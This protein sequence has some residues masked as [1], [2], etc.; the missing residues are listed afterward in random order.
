ME[1]KGYELPNVDE[2][3]TPERAGE[4]LN[5]LYAEGLGDLSHPLMDGGHV[6]HKDFLKRMD[7]LQTIKMSND[8]MLTDLEKAMQA[9]LDGVEE[10]QNARVEEAQKLMD[11]LVDLGFPRT[12]IPGDITRYEIRGL[13][14]QLLASKGQ[15]DEVLPQVEEDLRKLSPPGHIAKILETIRTLPDSERDVREDLFNK[16]VLWIHKEKNRRFG[17]IDVF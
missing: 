3:T 6:Q 9:A 4:M 10:R 7:E 17:R 5:K 13:E 11:E 14:Q 16:V 15:W 1:T 2:G 12:K 8:V